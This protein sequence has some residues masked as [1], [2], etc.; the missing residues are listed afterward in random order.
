MSPWPIGDLPATGV[1]NSEF[2]SSGSEN[3]RKSVKYDFKKPVQR[4]KEPSFPTPEA[5]WAFI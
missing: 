2:V 1:D 4:V 3:D 5:K